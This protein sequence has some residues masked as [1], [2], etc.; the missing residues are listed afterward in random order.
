MTDIDPS[1]RRDHTGGPRPKVVALAV[2]GCAVAGA[3]AFE[4]STTLGAVVF[5]S[6][7]VAALCAVVFY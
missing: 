5:L 1:P 4:E 6:L 7:L 3:V 2:V